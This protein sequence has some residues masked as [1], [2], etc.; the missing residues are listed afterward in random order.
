MH[1]GPSCRFILTRIGPRHS[2]SLMTTTAAASPERTSEVLESL[3]GIRSRIRAASV[4]QNTP[5]LLAVS[6]YKPSSDILACYR[7]GQLDFAENYAQELVAKVAEVS[8]AYRRLV[9]IAP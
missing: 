7:G 6:K 8:S 4:Q 9:K 1:I 5:I 3:S 2:R